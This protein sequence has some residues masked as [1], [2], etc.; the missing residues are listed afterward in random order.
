MELL[1]VH[2]I[3]LLVIILYFVYLEAHSETSPQEVACLTHSALL[4]LIPLS[5]KLNC[6]LY[7]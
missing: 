6:S 1:I 7:V 5:L 2:Q 3:L 4:R